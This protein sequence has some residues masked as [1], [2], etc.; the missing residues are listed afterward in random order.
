MVAEAC[1]LTLALTLTVGTLDGWPSPATKAKLIKK[2][3]RIG[4]I[5]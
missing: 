2:S 5:V 4:G 3:A 1:T